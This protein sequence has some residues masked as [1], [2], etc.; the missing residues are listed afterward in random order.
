[1]CGI[2]GYIGPKKN[3]AQLVLRG[4]KKLEYR[5]Y[6]SWGIVVEASSSNTQAQKLVVEKHI[7][8]ITEVNLP[9]AF[10]SLP[11]GFAL[12]HTR[13]A[14]HG[15]V[16]DIN[17]HP[18]L[19]CSGKIAII[20]NGIIENYDKIKE[21][22]IKLGHKFISETDSEV[23][24]H[25]IEEYYFSGKAAGQ[26]FTP[27]A[28]RR[29]A[30]VSKTVTRRPHLSFLEAVRRAFLEFEG[31]NAIIAMCSQTGEFVAAK[32]GSPL[33][34]GFGKGEN[35]LASDAPALL[36]HT[37]RVHFIEDGQLASVT[38]DKIELF[39]V[40]TGKREE[41]K[42]EILNWKIEEAEKGR[43]PHFM[44]K[45][46]IEQPKVLRGII[47]AVSGQIPNLSQIIKGAYGSYMVGCGTAS[48]A[49]LS[50]TYL[51][52][53]IAHR[54]VN[55]SAGSEF[56]Y[57]LNFLTPKSLVIAFSQSGET[58]DIVESMTKAKA[59]G[60][61][62]LAVVNVLGSTL[63]RM[64]DY[65]L[66]LGAGPEKCVLSTK[67]FTAKLAAL[68]LMAFALD[69]YLAKGK[70]LL[71]QAVKAVEKILKSETQNNIKELTEK[72]ANQEHIY[73][74]GRGQSYPVA[75][76]AALKIKEV[77][78]IHAE[79]FA[80]GEL[81]HGV[82]A[83][84]EKGTPCL[85]FAPNDETYGAVLSGAMEMRARGGLIIGVSFKNH[86]VFDYFIP[87]SDCGDATSIPNTVVAQL[88]GYYLC[89]KKGYDPDKPRNLAKSV[90]V[91]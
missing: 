86:E 10:L 29:A 63:Y 75:L 54:H 14:T 25:L 53:R 6:D 39:N 24:A 36:V 89:L 68:I 38:K 59:K 81:K 79:G 4:L 47:Q 40:N 33:V 31:L 56:N 52:N 42:I 9:S 85:V 48:Y 55:F 83:L 30:E 51:F 32:T 69:G 16:T 91:K 87:V 19:D 70:A 64:A 80:A 49:A 43:Y 12:G 74:I 3:A 22:L 1:M 62:I 61:K 66:L 46:I 41:P 50:G 71:E 26:K 20:H 90:T 67:T 2:F 21:R 8:K 60:A 18:H 84:I 13:W 77:S 35:F 28:D 88:L 11:S 17:A 72:I 76:E 73:I 65:K 34:V 82:I 23:A 45:E 78:Y 37:R 27:Q 58:I 5:G 44:I 7:G 57:L 15:G